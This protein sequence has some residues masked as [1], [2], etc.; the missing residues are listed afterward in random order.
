MTPETFEDCL[1]F[2]NY[3]SKWHQHI[4]RYQEYQEFL[5]LE[6]MRLFYRKK[7]KE[8]EE[9]RKGNARVTWGQRG[10]YL[11]NRATANGSVKQDSRQHRKETPRGMLLWLGVR[12]HMLEERGRQRTAA[13]SN[14]EPC[15]V[16]KGAAAPAARR[17]LECCGHALSLQAAG[18]GVK[19]VYSGD[20]VRNTMQHEIVNRCT[21][22]A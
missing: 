7:R 6:C 16:S 5:M 9:I 8:N 22:T 13:N 14:G 4:N 2:Q 11:V 12:Q 19:W 20:R 3:R 21:A 18:A 15:A 17:M 1:T 10:G